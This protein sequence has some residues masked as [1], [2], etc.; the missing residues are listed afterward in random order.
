MVTAKTRTRFAP[1]NA[2]KRTKSDGRGSKVRS[3]LDASNKKERQRLQV[4]K[5]ARRWRSKG[6][7]IDGVVRGIDQRE[8]KIGGTSDNNMSLRALSVNRKDGNAGAV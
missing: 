5:D 1:L 8:K 6:K 2:G 7:L 3:L 4:G